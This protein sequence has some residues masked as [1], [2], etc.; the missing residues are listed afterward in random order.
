MSFKYRLATLFML[1]TTGCQAG[2]QQ[3][4]GFYRYGHEVNSVCTGVPEACYWLVDTPEELRQRL[5]QQVAGK[6]PYAP[7]CLK[8]I[9]ELSDEKADGFGLDYDGSIRVVQL[10]G[11]CDGV[12]DTAISLQDLQH[13]RFV[14]ERINDMTLMQYA[15]ELGFTEAE[16]LQKIP[17]LDFGEQG[18]V[19]G[20]T[21]C[22]QVSGQASVT[23]NTLTLGPLASTRMYC[24]GFSGEL[25]LQ[26]SM[27]YDTG[28]AITR[29]GQWLVLQAGTTKLEY[30]LKDWVQ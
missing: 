26:L 14:L 24:P 8:L 18:F 29:I 11:G 19:S 28:L 1:L 22:N 9:A 6:P 30:Q 2:L 7:V 23:D 10:L 4:D 27:H 3:I 25:E 12:K 16:P 5:K 13:H 21:G 17:E 15:Q 20:N